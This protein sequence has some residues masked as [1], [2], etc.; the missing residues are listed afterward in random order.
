MK[1]CMKL[2][3]TTIAN[4]GFIWWPSVDSGNK[5]APSAFLA[6][7]A[8]CSGLVYSIIPPHLQGVPIPSRSEALIQWSRGHNL[9][10][11]MSTCE[12]QQRTWNSCQWK[13]QWQQ[14][15][16]LYVKVEATLTI[17]SQAP[18]WHQLLFLKRHGAHLCNGQGCLQAVPF[19][20][21]T[22]ELTTQ[23]VLLLA[24]G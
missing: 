13:Y 16:V 1:S 20:H 18:W 23:F 3:V 5:L 6:S 11:P 12:Q 10:P 15:S 24:F 17:L 14:R 19:P 4:I 2:I 9:S 22:E 7:A 8:A 21:L